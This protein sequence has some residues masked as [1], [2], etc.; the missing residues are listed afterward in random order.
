MKSFALNA[1]WQVWPMIEENLVLW[2]VRFSSLFLFL[3]TVTCHGMQSE[4][5]EIMVFAAASLT[6]VLDAI[7]IEFKSETNF[8][9]N[10][11]GS[12]MLASQILKGASA[13]VFIAAGESPVQILDR[14]DMIYVEPHMILANKL[15]VVT[16]KDGVF[17]DAFDQLGSDRIQR[18]SIADP[19]LAPAG[20]YAR[21]ALTTLG[22]WNELKTKTVLAYDVRAAMVYVQTGNAEAAIVYET[23]AVTGSNL[24]LHD[25]VPISSYEPIVYPLII[26]KDSDKKKQ[27]NTFLD[28]L[29]SDRATEIFLRYGFHRPQH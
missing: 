24:V 23:D 18:L 1:R 9:V 5:D 3:T 12:Q 2:I 6:D 28:L 14:S 19:S 27:S 26:L 17:L 25:I 16:R 13:D 15:V 10:Y 29:L 8:V 21:E 4:E 7:Q 11:G 22:I 20:V